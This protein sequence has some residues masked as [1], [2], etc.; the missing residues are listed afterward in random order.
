MALSRSVNKIHLSSSSLRE[1]RSKSRSVRNADKVSPRDRISLLSEIQSACDENL[2]GV[3]GSFLPGA[4]L[5]VVCLA[6]VTLPPRYR[7]NGG[8]L[9]VVVSLAVVL[10]A[11]GLYAV[12]LW[13]GCR[14]ASASAW[15][16]FWPPMPRPRCSGRLARAGSGSHSGVKLWRS[17]T[18]KGSSGGRKKGVV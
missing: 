8:R 16:P 12:A 13:R 11:D 14:S 6:V 17:R 5:V 9:S 18:G 7:T 15:G 2:G 1:S 3:C 10:S 4:A